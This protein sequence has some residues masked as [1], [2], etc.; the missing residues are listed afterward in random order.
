MNFIP[1]IIAA[2]LGLVGTTQALPAAEA[3]HR[4]AVDCVHWSWKL[5][6]TSCVKS[7]ITSTP[8]AAL[9]GLATAQDIS[10]T[11]DG[12]VTSPWMLDSTPC[13]TIATPNVT[14][15]PIVMARETL[16]TT[17]ATSSTTG[18]DCLNWP[19]TSVDNPC[20]T[21]TA[22]PTGDLLSAAI[23]A[24]QDT[25]TTSTSTDTW[26][27]DWPWRPDGSPCSDI[28][29][30]TPT[31]SLPT[32]MLVARI[33]DAMNDDCISWPWVCSSSTTTTSTVSPPS[34]MLVARGT[35]IP[36]DDC[37]SWPWTC[38]SSATT[39]TTTAPNKATPGP[40]DS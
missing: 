1:F 23:M 27:I 21:V 19:W 14:L 40:L 22:A 38:S 24:R 36:D 37:I 32:T 2:I 20:S 17:T 12:C 29:T 39:T 25:T 35:E 5:Q 6:A 31:P 7:L 26:C 30:A 16:T 34:A 13:T 3:D 10:S 9:A 18:I 33:T 11:V 15:T 28:T 4:R 8:T